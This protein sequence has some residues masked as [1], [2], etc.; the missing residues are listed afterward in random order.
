[1]WALAAV[2]TLN[3]HLSKAQFPESYTSSEILHDLL[4]AEKTGTIMYI[5]AHPDDE[6]TRLISYFVNHMHARTVYLSLT[7]GD[8]GQNLIGTETG[9]A[10]GVLRTQ[11]LLEA[12][13]IDGGEQW[14]TRAVD[15]GYSKSSLETLAKWDRD[16]IL[17]DVVR[18]I[19]KFRPDV[20]VTRFPP[21]NYAGHGHHEA[22]ALLAEEAFEAAGDPN[23]FP[24][25]KLDPW[26]PTRL[27]FNASTWWNKDL[28]QRARD[29]DNFVRVNVGDYN[30][31]LGETYARIAARSRSS[32]RSQGFGTDVYYGLNIEYMEYVKGEK[33]RSRDDILAGIDCSWKRLEAEPVGEILAEAV[34]HFDHNAPEATVPYLADALDALKAAPPSPLR[35]YK[36]GELEALLAKSA[37]I[38][39]EAVA[40]VPYYTPGDDAFVQVNIVH[41]HRRPLHVRKIEGGA[42]PAPAHFRLSKG[43]YFT[44]EILIPIPDDANPSNPYWLNEPYEYLFDIPNR[45]LAGRPENPPALSV[46]LDLEIEGIESELS[47]PVVHKVADPVK[48]VIYRPVEILPPVTFS[49]SEEVILSTN[50]SEQAV[51]LFLTNHTDSASGEV[52]LK[53]PEGHISEP[54]SVRYSSEKKGNTVRIVFSV[55]GK[56]GAESGPVK[57]EYTPAGG[58]PFEKCLTLKE[59]SYDH[60]YDQIILQPAEVQLESFQLDR[61]DVARI[62]Y[63]EGPGDDVAKYLR[64]AGY[65]VDIIDEEAILSGQLHDY[66]AVMTGIRAF[67]TREELAYLNEK[68]NAYVEAGGTWLVQYNTAHRLKSDQIGPYPFKIGRERVTDEDAEPTLTVPGHPAFNRPNKLNPDDFTGWVQERGLYFAE[69][70]D[71]RFTPLIS[72]SDPDEP[73]RE[74]SLIVAPH[75]KGYFIYSGISFFRQLPAGVPG[76]YRL[77]SNILNLKSNGEKP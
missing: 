37:G 51:T 70:W 42:G 7:R 55:K 53:L 31:L 74:G 13:K 17:S 54:E 41:Q 49:F 4:K 12:R 71:D 64:A 59:V 27:Y 5:A 57:V 19:R 29:N 61:G 33:A 22:S 44:K 50:Q 1:M 72:W 9:A 67:N 48:A 47:L 60:I 11:E 39:A 32:H 8:G 76:A 35:T 6:N 2:L 21:N 26:Q 16:T 73:P 40:G 30:P 38:Y 69:T 3:G 28:A 63:F 65:A 75:G 43:E 14:F 34:E 56:P 45:V 58:A 18:A 62:G 23:K 66:D 68:L 52:R 36:M 10:M 24:E 20:L 77:M 46:K 25:H 15:F